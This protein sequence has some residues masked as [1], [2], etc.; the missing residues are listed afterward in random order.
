MPGYI[1]L[2]CLPCPQGTPRAFWCA[3]RPVYVIFRIFQAQSSLP[4]P[5]TSVL[6]YFIFPHQLF[7]SLPALLVFRLQYKNIRR[8]PALRGAGHLTP[9]NSD[10]EQK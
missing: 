7:S 2:P 6:M 9:N 8:R 10:N 4:L 5:T 3:T 1:V